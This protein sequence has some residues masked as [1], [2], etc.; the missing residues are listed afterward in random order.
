VAYVYSD[1]REGEFVE[2]MLREFKGVLVSDFYAVYD[3]L[4]CPQQKCLIHLM[5]DLNAELLAQPYDEE[6]KTIVRGFADL[7]RPMVETVDRFGLKTHFLRKHRVAVERFYR[8]LTKTDWQS[9][10]AIKCKQRFEK[11]RYKLFT[12]LEYDGVPWNNN[13]AEHAIKAFASLRNVIRGSCTK[14]ALQEYL[15]LLSVCQTCEYQGIDLLDFLRS[16]KKH[17]DAFPEFG[18]VS[19]EGPQRKVTVLRS[20]T[21]IC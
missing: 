3:A 2:A 16:G 11:N 1:T 8:G 14:E 20:D 18:V 15:I 4:D 10:A 6:F 5:R 13:N 12:F 7:L 19:R 21:G 17:I 9:E